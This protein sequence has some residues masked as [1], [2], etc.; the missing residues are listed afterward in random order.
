MKKRDLFIVVTES[1]G[2][3]SRDVGVGYFDRMPTMEEMV[4]GFLDNLEGNETYTPG[5]T[6][7]MLKIVMRGIPTPPEGFP[8]HVSAVL[9]YPDG[10]IRVTRGNHYSLDES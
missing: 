1:K 10:S 3:D 4:N 5:F 9:E 6:E 7:S 2:P 8:P